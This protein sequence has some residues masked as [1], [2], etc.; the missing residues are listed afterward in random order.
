M[1]HTLWVQE[2]VRAYNEARTIITTKQKEV[3]EQSVL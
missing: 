3:K 1:G 2:A